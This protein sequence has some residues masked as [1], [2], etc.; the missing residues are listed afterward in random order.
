MYKEEILK[1]N[2]NLIDI[3]ISIKNLENDESVQIY[4]QYKKEEL[5]KDIQSLTSKM[6]SQCKH[7]IWYHIETS[8]DAFEGRTYY[9]C[10]CLECGYQTERRGRDFNGIV[11]HIKNKFSSVQDKYFEFKNITNDTNIIRTLLQENFKE[12]PETSL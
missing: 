3:N 2:K 4:N 8:T 5:N 1:L 7:P 9:L 11:I 12:S 10:K 6:Q